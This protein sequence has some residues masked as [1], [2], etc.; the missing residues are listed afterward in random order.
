MD[1]SKAIIPLGTMDS[2]CGK[3]AEDSACRR[4][5]ADEMTTPDAFGNHPV[6]HNAKNACGRWGVAFRIRYSQAFKL[7]ASI[8]GGRR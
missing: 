2:S 3:Y 5:A 6:T 1:F 8:L 4:Y 7:G